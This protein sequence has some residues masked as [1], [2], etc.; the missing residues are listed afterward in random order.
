MM[1]EQDVRAAVLAVL[2][3]DAA[4]MAKVNRV[5]DG[6]PAK[7]TLPTCVLGESSGTD[8]GCKDR[9]GR[10]VRITLTIEDDMESTS[11]I[12]TILP[13]AEAAVQSLSGIVPEETGTTG[14]GAGWAIASLRPVRSRLLRTNSGRWNALLDYRIR[15]LAA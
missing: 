15:V 8:W 2:R 6:V 1:A 5:Y 12:S 3:G 10:E 14:G 13:I 11:R 4:L 7:A 9:P